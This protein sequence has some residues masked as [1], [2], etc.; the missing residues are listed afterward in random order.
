MYALGID[1]GTT[2]T[3]AAV[4]RD[5][6]AEICPLGTRSAAVPTVVLLREDGETV[7]GEAAGRRG[8][9][10]PDRVAREFK[11]RLGDPTPVLLGGTPFSAEALMSRVLRAVVADVARREGG[12]P[13]RVCVTHPA[14]W[15]PFKTDLLRQAV[16]SAGLHDVLLTTE[17]EAAAVFY[18]RQ[19]RVPDGAVVAVYDLGGGTFDAAVLRKTGGGFTILGRPEGIDQLG[20]IDVDAAVLGHVVRALGG[21]WEELDEDDPA[22]VA[23]TARLR[24]ECVAAKEALSADTDTT[25]PVLLPGLVTQVRLTRAELEGMVRPALQD[26]LDAL[27]RA[28][29][30]AGVAPA[31]LDAVLLVGGASRMPLVAQLVGAGLGRPV[32]V[33]A[34]PKHAVALGASWL[35]AGAAADLPV[36]AQATRRATPPPTGDLRRADPTEIPP[37]PADPT[38]TPAF[39]TGLAG[40][41]KAATTSGAMSGARSGATSGATGSP[42]ARRTGRTLVAVLVAAAVLG[43]G[44]GAVAA[45]G[46]RDGAPGAGGTLTTAPRTTPGTP[47]TTPGTPRTPATSR[48]AST[49]T[50]AR[51]S[52][53]QCTR[54]IRANPRWVCLR[55]ATFDGLTLTIEYTGSFAGD[56]PDVHGGYHLHVYGGDGTTPAEA[57]MGVQASDP[58]H[59]YVEDARPSVRRASS[60]DFVRA[61]GDAPKVCARIADGRHRLVP[62]RSGGFRT[63]NCVPITRV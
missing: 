4:H 54:A 28:L 60:Q 29:R 42:A 50:V 47:R 10:A 19:Q 45:F 21:A 43:A 55:S 59:W 22:V 11:R 39:G 62:D 57:D 58:G 5:G 36:A 30:S 6:R 17:P 41:V 51:P 20:G 23:A 49:T 33:D 48:T 25:V 56:R 13:A 46:G 37:P 24:E 53:E 61:V 63:G 26:T 18:A 52:D 7:T 3:A 2:F 12:A 14:N 31:E 32:A 9:A 35:A 38:P 27:D 16:R 34:H 15:G 44:A 1:L 40:A 8:L